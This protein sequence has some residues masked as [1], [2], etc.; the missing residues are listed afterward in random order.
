MKCLQIATNCSVPISHTSQHKDKAYRVS[1]ILSQRTVCLQ[2]ATN[3]SVYI[4][5]KKVQK[6]IQNVLLY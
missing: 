3:C 6:F 5:Q 4:S 2:I 1:L